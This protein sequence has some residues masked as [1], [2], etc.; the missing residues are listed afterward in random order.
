MDN[1]AIRCLKSSKSS[2]TSVSKKSPKDSLHAIG[3]LAATH[4]ARPTLGRSRLD[5]RRHACL[6]SHDPLKSNTHICGN[7][8]RLCFIESEDRSPDRDQTFPLRYREQSNILLK[9]IHI[10]LCSGQKLLE[11]TLAMSIVKHVAHKGIIRRTPS[12]PYSYHIL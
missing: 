6:V 9:Y 3:A 8:H 10:K 12:Y 7:R 4:F 2:A 11:E 5:L 1:L